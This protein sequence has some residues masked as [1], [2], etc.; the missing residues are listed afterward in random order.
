MKKSGK[1]VKLLQKQQK[2]S[3]TAGYLD[4][5]LKCLQLV[6]HLLETRSLKS[7]AIREKVYPFFQIW[8]GMIK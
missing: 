1:D 5:R 4:F 7:L 2:T 8:V 3:K 6:H